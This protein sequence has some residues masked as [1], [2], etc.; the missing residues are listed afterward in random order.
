[1]SGMPTTETWTG[2]REVCCSNH[3]T[4]RAI[5]FCC[6]CFSFAWTTHCPARTK[7]LAVTP[8]RIGE[9]ADRI[10]LSARIFI[11]LTRVTLPHFL[12]QPWLEFC[13]SISYLPEHGELSRG[14]VPQGAVGPFAIVVVP[15]GFLLFSCILQGQEPVLVQAF[16]PE[17]SVE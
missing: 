7:R 10:N 9:T 1:M 3:M 8:I 5:S 16:L 14:Q 13:G 12:Y 6:S 2:F 11:I 15:P 17:P 4:S